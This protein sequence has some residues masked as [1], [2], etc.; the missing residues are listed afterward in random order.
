MQPRC[1]KPHWPVWDLAHLH[2][3][4]ECRRELGQFMAMIPARISPSGMIYRCLLLALLHCVVLGA[5]ASC[6]D[7]GPATVPCRAE[8]DFANVEVA[9][10]SA[11]IP[12]LGGPNV[13]V[14][15]ADLPDAPSADAFLSAVGDCATYCSK[16][17]GAGDFTR[18]GVRDDPTRSTDGAPFWVFECFQH[19]P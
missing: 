14:P 4:A 3:V 8:Q 2:A 12:G 19:C 18:C 11:T 1:S 5:L 7:G 15:V 6:S 13:V 17:L 10:G 16:L 9:D